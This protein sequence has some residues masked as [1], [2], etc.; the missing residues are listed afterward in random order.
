MDEIFIIIC[1]ILYI[2]VIILCFLSVFFDIRLL[3]IYFKHGTIDQMKIYKII[4]IFLCLIDSL[5]NLNINQVFKSN[6]LC[7]ITGTLKFPIQIGI[8][9]IQVS[10]VII[11]YFSLNHQNWIQK[12]PIIFK[13][14]IMSISL[15][16]MIFTGIQEFYFSFT[17]NYMRT[18]FCI[19]NIINMY[20]LFFLFLLA[21]SI[22]FIIFFIMLYKTVNQLSKENPDMAEKYKANLKVYFY[23]F[24]LSFPIAFFCIFII[25]LYKIIEHYFPEI[26][27]EKVINILQ[28]IA[29]LFIV[30]LFGLSPIAVVIIY[31]FN[32]EHLHL[33]KH[34]FC[35]C[36]KE[37]QESNTKI[38]MKL[39]EEED[40]EQSLIHE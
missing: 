17:T 19:K 11:T 35:C 1:E 7:E 40:N 24:C 2:L 23:G 16:P 20:S 34:I 3:V 21:F 38:S 29:A 10:L 36:Y 4:L 25:G 18:L 32:K 27:N 9:S 33:F 13:C 28:F 39:F 31:C 22:L 5:C 8:E 26:M 6:L 37:E 14:I 30:L 15:L 12:N